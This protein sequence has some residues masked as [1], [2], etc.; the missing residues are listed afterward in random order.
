MSFRTFR[1]VKM[2]YWQGRKLPVFL[3]GKDFPGVL[4]VLK[5]PKGLLMGLHLKGLR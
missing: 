1:T 4:T 3:P 5:V 2:P